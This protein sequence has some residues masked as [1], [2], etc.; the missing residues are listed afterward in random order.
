MRATPEEATILRNVMSELEY[1]GNKTFGVIKNSLDESFMD[2]EDLLNIRVSGA[3]KAIDEIDGL[4]GQM[5]NVFQSDFATVS[6]GFIYLDEKI[7]N[8]Y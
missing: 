6:L 3:E 7:K 5:T 1:T 8:L 2:A 4:T